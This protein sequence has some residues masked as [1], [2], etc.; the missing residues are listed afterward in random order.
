MISFTIVPRENARN[1][2]QGLKTIAHAYVV[3]I[4][5]AYGS[6]IVQPHSSF[7]L[8][9]RIRHTI[10]VKHAVLPLP[11]II[12]SR[13]QIIMIRLVHVSRS[14][15]T[16]RYSLKKMTHARKGNLNYEWLKLNNVLFMTHIIIR[17]VFSKYETCLVG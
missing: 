7:S 16:G 6:S 3:L 14:L 10:H 13:E 8:Q 1:Y 4:E 5:R 17:P 11:G 9:K 15:V 12:C 2:L